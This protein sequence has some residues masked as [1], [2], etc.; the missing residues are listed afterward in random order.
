MTRFGSATWTLAIAPGPWTQLYLG[1]MRSGD[2]PTMIS[3]VKRLGL[4]GVVFHAG[5]RSLVRAAPNCA[6]L[7]AAHGVAFGWALGADGDEDSDKSRL[8]VEEKA[9]CLAEVCERFEP[10]FAVVNAEVEWDTDRGDDD[11]MDEAGALRMGKRFRARCPRVVVI[12]QPWFAMDSHGEER[13]Q[14]KSI[15]QGGT[16][17][18]FPSD[19]FAS[20]VD[21]RAPQVYFRNFGS[22]DPTAYARVV[23]WHERDWAK[24]DASL[25]RAGLVR[26]RTYTLQG[27]GH[28]QRPQDFVDALLWLRD[29]PSILW[30]DHEYAQRWP[31]TAA[32]L[33][34]VNRILRD[35]HA[36][37][38]REPRECVR[39][40]QRS[41]GLS[42]AQIDGLCGW[43]TIERA[44]IARR[45]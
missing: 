33:E 27:Y 42:G 25:A 32:C 34:A 9:D 24:H 13:K 15:N 4:P 1:S 22:G 12:D 3:E 36:P 16:F 20:W 41:L 38:G 29:R 19:E 7:A 17:A 26:P 31:V 10:A 8:T 39:S 6:R 40:W 28:H 44:G 23:A 37:D 21:G 11:D 43:G 14:A 45:P 5:P 30:W 2:V 18:G 35:G